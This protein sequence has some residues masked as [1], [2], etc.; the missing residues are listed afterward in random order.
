MKSTKIIGHLVDSEV[1]P[2][3]WRIDRPG[4]GDGRDPSRAY[5][6]LNIAVLQDVTSDRRTIAAARL[7]NSG[8][9]AAVLPLVEALTGENADLWRGAA[10]AL[11]QLGIPNVNAFDPLVTLLRDNDS[12]VRD[13]AA[14]ALLNLWDVSCSASDPYPMPRR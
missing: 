3:M 11:G 12:S 8:D 10:R 7:G 14:E 13:A 6:C 4:S 5:M 9:P 1:S 2:F